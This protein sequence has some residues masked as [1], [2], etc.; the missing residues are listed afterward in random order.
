MKVTQLQILLRP[1]SIHVWT[2]LKPAMKNKKLKLSTCKSILLKN[3]TYV[4]ETPK[5]VT[6]NFNE[7]K[8][9]VTLRCTSDR[10]FTN[11]SFE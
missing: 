5:C 8:Y 9:V 10:H 11:D 6:L 7:G 3:A 4:R 2:I 1:V